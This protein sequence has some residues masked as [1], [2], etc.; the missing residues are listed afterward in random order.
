MV[1]RVS[2]FSES[3]DV[4][5]PDVLAVSG[6]QRGS[7]PPVRL[8]PLVFSEVKNERMNVKSTAPTTQLDV[9]HPYLPVL[10]PLECLPSSLSFL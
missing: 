7:A 6:T 8:G 5:T 10:N 1:P 4:T 2:N 9:L 3:L